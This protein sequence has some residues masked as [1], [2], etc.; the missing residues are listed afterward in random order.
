MGFRFAEDQICQVVIEERGIGEQDTV[1]TEFLS[2][3]RNSDFLW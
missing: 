1:R 3:R 2:R